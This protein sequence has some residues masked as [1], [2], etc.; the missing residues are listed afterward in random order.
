MTTTAYDTERPPRRLAGVIDNATYAL[1][2]CTEI[3]PAGVVARA[4]VGFAFAYLAFFWNDPGWADP[5]FGFVVI[6][7][8]VTALLALRARRTQRPLLATGP[9]GHLANAALFVPLFAHPATV[10]TALLFYGGSMLIAAA[11]RTGGCEVTAIS[12]ALLGRDDQ[13][14]CVLFAPVDLAEARFRRSGTEL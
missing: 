7:A 5:L 10:G 1:R 14:G 13:V 4:A 11:R 9:L 6:P 2:D 8:A 3:G 12:N